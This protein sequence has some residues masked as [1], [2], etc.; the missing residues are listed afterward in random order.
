MGLRDGLKNYGTPV[1]TPK[2]ST[3]VLKTVQCQGCKEYMARYVAKSEYCY[4]ICDECLEVF[5]KNRRRDADDKA[6]MQVHMKSGVRW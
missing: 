2:N 3:D 4:T 6:E 1:N 5:A